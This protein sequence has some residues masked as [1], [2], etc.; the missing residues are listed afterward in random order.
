MDITYRPFFRNPLPDEINVDLNDP[1]EIQQYRPKYSLKDKDN[2]SPSDLEETSESEETTVQSPIAEIQEQSKNTYSGDKY[3]RF[4]EAYN[5]SGVDAKW[6]DFFSKLAHKESGFDP[7][8]QNMFGA[9]AYG[10]F[11]F[12]Q[13]SANGRNW[14]NI[15]TY[16]NTDIDT[17]RNSPELQI[18]AAQKLA[19][20]FLKGLTD[21]DKKR[22]RELGYSDSALVAGAWLG[23]IGGVRKLL[24]QNKSVNDKSWSK[25]KN[26]GVDMKSRMEEFN[27][28]FKDGGVIKFQK[29]GI[30]E[31]KEWLKNWYKNRKFIL[32][33]NIQQNQ[34]IPFP[35]TANFGYNILTKNMDL[36]TASVNPA[37]VPEEA[38][39]VYYPIGRRI[40]LRNDSPSTAVHEWT[41]SSNPKP[42]IKEIDKIKDTLGQSIYDQK[43][44]IP[45]NYLDSSNEIYSRLMQLRYNLN[46]DPNHVFTNKEIEELKRKYTK[47]KTL[48]TRL[49]G[50]DYNSFT[51]T[52]FDKDN[53]ITNIEPFNPNF[54]ISVDESV[55][56][57]NYDQDN[58]FNILN[59]YSTNFIRRLLN[60]VAWDQT[61]KK[62]TSLYAKLGLKVPKYQYSGVLKD[63]YNDPSEYYDYSA[64]EYDSTTQHWSSRDPRTGLLL[65][66]PKHPTFYKSV[67]EDEKLGYELYQDISTGRYYT[68][69]P[70]EYITSSKKLTLRKVSDD[71]RRELLGRTHLDTWRNR[72]D[73][74]QV[75]LGFSK[76]TLDNRK[77]PYVSTIL[78]AAENQD[79][80]PEILDAL[81]TQESK[82]D[83]NAESSAGAKGI[84]QLTDVN[85]KDIDPFN[86]YQNIPRSSEVLAWF[87]NRN[88]GDIK[89]AIAGYNGYTKPENAKRKMEKE[90]SLE[91]ARGKRSDNYY[92]VL[93]DLI[94]SL[95]EYSTVNY[96]FKKPSN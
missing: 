79:I 67:L 95:K 45:D 26:V 3:N 27:N 83:P 47:N 93:Y 10:Y 1:I 9:P 37:Q 96:P 41:H 54:K 43:S 69:N 87:R 40:Y 21:K 16:A 89:R 6:F 91:V 20:S 60:D 46:A 59:R 32:K 48:T 33:N 63:T 58:T 28:F 24:Y 25:N 38:V 2:E 72:P 52:T 70:E 8:I 84:G 65:K 34:T 5:N 77:A 44:V 88:N 68:L 30:T 13:G 19:E 64:G 53:N 29:G 66:N 92:E 78:K 71:E 7:N 12:M 4:V 56:K 15:T 36:T 86:P 81:F 57:T 42:Q 85:T 51:T 23:G 11:Q 62:D 76:D 35:I 39:G 75:V 80:N 55:V 18:Q 49:L 90:D 50:N 14:N 82:Y 31:G 17:F 73:F 94:D 22:A 61:K 74:N